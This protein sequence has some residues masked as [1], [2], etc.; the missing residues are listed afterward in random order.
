M[1]FVVFPP[2]VW[3]EENLDAMPRALSGAGVGPGGRINEVD[4][5]VNSLMLVTLR[6]EIAVRTPTITNDRGAGFN[7]VTY[8]DHHCVGGSALEGN[9]KCFAGLSFHVSKHPLTLNSVSLMKLSPAELAVVNFYGL[10]RTSDLN[11]AAL[12]T[13]QHGF[14][15]EHAPVCG[16]MISKAIFASDFVGRFA[17]D[18][19]V[20]N[21]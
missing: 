9:K 18:D 16:R 4:T 1:V 12:Q 19:V 6:T 2:I 10:I 3:S 7:P 11:A 5:V 20:S 14:P 17:V 15:A 13:H 21:K 8:N